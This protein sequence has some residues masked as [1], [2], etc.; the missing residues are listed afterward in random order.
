MQ[1][2]FLL[3]ILSKLPAALSSLG[4]SPPSYNKLKNENKIH[5]CEFVTVKFT[6][7]CTK[8]DSKVTV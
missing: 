2:A 3:Y 1:I 8:P 6:P 7:V 5:C 4:A